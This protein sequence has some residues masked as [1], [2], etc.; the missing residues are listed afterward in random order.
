SNRWAN[1]M[2]RRWWRAANWPTCSARSA[3]TPKR[4]NST[5]SRWPQWKT[6]S[7][8]TTRGWFAH[9]QTTPA[10]WKIG[11]ASHQRKS[12]RSIRCDRERSAH[13]Q[14]AQH[15]LESRHGAQ[16]IVDRVNLERGHRDFV[17]PAA[18]LEILQRPFVFPQPKMNDRKHSGR[19]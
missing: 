6:P 14:L 7:P 11:T 8:M 16:G 18:A 5:A 3:V 9:R 2:Q 12:Y 15:R 10:W 13:A 1:T 19:D 17:L 4:R